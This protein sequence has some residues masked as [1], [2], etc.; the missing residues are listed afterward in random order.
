VKSQCSTTYK[1]NSATLKNTICKSFF[2][3]ILLSLGCSTSNTQT[4]D[5]KPQVAIQAEINTDQAKDAKDKGWSHLLEVLAKEGVERKLA[6]K[7]LGSRDM[8][9]KEILTFNLNPKEKHSIYKGVNTLKRRKHALE[10]YSDHKDAFLKVRKNYG[11]PEG[12]VLAI[13]QVETSCGQF[14]GDKS[15]FPAIARLANARD[16]EVLFENLKNNEKSAEAAVYSRASYLETTFVPHLVATF[17]IAPDG[18]VHSLRGSFAG[19]MGLPQFMPDNILRYG[20]DANNDGLVDVYN[21]DDAILSTANYLKM[22]GWTALELPRSKRRN[23]IW[24]YNRSTPY[25]D[26]VLSMA[27]ELQKYITPEKKS[28]TNVDTKKPIGKP[29]RPVKKLRGGVKKSH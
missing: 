17:K 5:T 2:L 27:D 13:L 4:C 19:A 11:V 14:T 28:S 7:A 25:I 20:V 6:E 29:A 21:P 10:F 3:G 22:H 18:D 16:P 23:V 15:V 24:E 9:E 8:P 12:V 1:I 26:T